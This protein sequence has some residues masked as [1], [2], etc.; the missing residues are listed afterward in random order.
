MKKGRIW[1]VDLQDGAGHEQKGMRPCLI[2][3][4]ANDMIAIIPLTTNMSRINLDCTH[5]IE[6]TQENGLREPSVALIYQI[7][8]LDQSRFKNPLGYLSKEEREPID[9][10]L[11]D[12]LKLRPTG[13]NQ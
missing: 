12:L 2:A 13:E 7:R 5:A 1:W 9:E 3:G 11:K 4:K 10:I 6:P 8:S